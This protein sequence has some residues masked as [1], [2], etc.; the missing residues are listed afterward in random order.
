[1]IRFCF[2]SEDYKSQNLPT[3]KGIELNSYHLRINI[4]DTVVESIDELGHEAVALSLPGASIPVADSDVRDPILESLLLAL[5]KSVRVQTGINIKRDAPEIRDFLKTPENKV[6][7]FKYISMLQK[8]FDHVV[9]KTFGSYYDGV[10]GFE[11]KKDFRNGARMM[12]NPKKDLNS[13]AWFNKWLTS[14]SIDVR[15]FIIFLSEQRPKMFL[16]TVIFSS[17]PVFEGPSR[18]VEDLSS[19]ADFDF[20]VLKSFYGKGS[21][22]FDFDLHANHVLYGL[23]AQ[24]N[25]GL[26]KGRNFDFVTGQ[27]G[28]VKVCIQRVFTEETLSTDAING[29]EIGQKRTVSFEPRPG[30]IG[31]DIEEAF[32]ARFESTSVPPGSDYTKQ[33]IVDY[34]NSLPTASCIKLIA[35]MESGANLNAEGEAY[36]SQGWFQITYDGVYGTTKQEYRD[37]KHLFAYQKRLLQ[38]VNDK[39]IGMKDSPIMCFSNNYLKDPGANFESKYVEQNAVYYVTAFNPASGEKFTFSHPVSMDYLVYKKY[40]FSALDVSSFEYLDSE[41][42]EIIGYTFR[43]LLENG[44]LMYTTSKNGRRVKPW[45]E[46][47]V[48]QILGASLSSF[49]EAIV[50]KKYHSYH[51]ATSDSLVGVKEVVDGHVS[52]W[53]LMFDNARYSEASF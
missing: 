47:Y 44:F 7:F 31:A 22:P 12:E 27:D 25:H 53:T 10:S 24:G 34:T 3:P 2:S 30:S 6:I 39:F 37:N 20:G 45:D 40:K 11:I 9:D 26:M 23:S 49:R 50:D 41:M 42:K 13:S 48:T 1:M 51:S 5:T 32:L 18:L 43:E 19:R 4:V 33:D 15:R 29:H 8:E 38:A 21:I 28:L 35:L 36:G 14:F 17:L 16:M 46:S 52:F